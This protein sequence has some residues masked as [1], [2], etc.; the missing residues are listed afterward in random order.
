[1]RAWQLDQLNALWRHCLE[2]VPYY[3]RL[4]AEHRLPPRFDS[5]EHYA[6]AVPLLAKQAVRQSSH[7]FVSAIASTGREI[8][9]PPRR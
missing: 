2:H 9:R 4:A 7:D 6:T 1:M 8:G 3:H 5:L